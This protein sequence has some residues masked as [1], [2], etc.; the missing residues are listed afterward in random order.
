AEVYKMFASGELDPL[1]TEITFDEIPEGL[2]QLE[3]HE[4]EGRLVVKIQVKRPR[5]TK[6]GVFFCGKIY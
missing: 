2:E 3:R 5:F 1:L 6:Y 4:V